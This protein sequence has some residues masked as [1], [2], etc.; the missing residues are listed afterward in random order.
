MK[1]IGIVIPAYNEEAMIERIIKSLPRA[2]DG[3]PTHIIVVVDG[4]QDKTEEKAR[5][6]GVDVISHIINTGAGGATRTGIHYAR[7]IGS[8]IVA[9][10][11]ADG[12]H[13]SED[14]VAVVRAV[15][16]NKGDLVIGSR[17]ID[18]KGMVLHR[19]IGN[20][21]LS[22]FTYLIFGAWVTDSQSGLKA[23][24]AR[25]AEAIQFHSNDFAFCS[26]I[27]WR[28][29]QQKLRI[30]EVPIKA[31]YTEYSL[32]KKHAQSKLNGIN[33]LMQMIKQRI[34]GILNG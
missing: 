29:K 23:F 21:G 31:I 19:L 6:T 18:P 22:L 7:L 10:I 16:K 24:N 13:R 26:E 20:V 25:A 33:M 34:M 3:H 28:A 5:K 17:L 27:I 14:L 11:D 15:L 2:I 30:H 12:Q 1:K 9:T 8:D 4:S 32:G